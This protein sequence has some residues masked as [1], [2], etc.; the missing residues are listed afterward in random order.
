MSGG[1][2][3]GQN[4][5]TQV[6]QIPQYEQD[7][8]AANQNL[9]QS[10]GSQN[11][12]TYGAPLIAGQTPLQQQGQTMATGAAT[13]WQPALGAASNVA[14]HALSND[15]VAAA[16]PF[17]D[18][19]AGTIAGGLA[20]DPANPG[21]ISSYMSPYVGAALA[22]QITALQTQLGQEHQNI[23]RGATG[24]G[25]FGDA[26]QGAYD[27]L[28]DFYGNQSLTGLLGAGYNTAYTNA[29]Q[30]AL[31]QEGA[32]IQGGTALGNLGLGRAGAG[33]QEQGVGLQG[34]STFGTLG[35]LDQSLGLTGANATYTA[36]QQQQQQQQQ[37]LN[38]A[39]QQ[40]LNQ[41]NWPF[42]MLNVRESALSN[43]PYNIATAVTLPQGNAAAQGFGGTTAA[44]STLA[45]LFGGGGGGVNFGGSG[46]TVPQRLQ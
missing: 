38:T 40:F 36:G 28:A 26:R 15:P 17:I 45:G 24:A 18:A 16:S 20:H 13:S 25:A 19:G 4:T 21:V 34:A 44:L 30:T 5:V 8:S 7:F 14:S 12:P 32:D 11:Y 41:V 31:G 23:A 1:D 27:S 42:Q 2:G 33:I 39:Y 29:L 3:G 6:Q 37:E 10:L 43:S 35:G 46:G 9:A 22:P